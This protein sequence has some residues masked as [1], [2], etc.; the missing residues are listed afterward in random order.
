MK[1]SFLNFFRDEKHNLI[2]IA[3]DIR[4]I[5]GGHDF[6]DRVLLVILADISILLLLFVCQYIFHRISSKFIFIR[7]KICFFNKKKKAYCFDKSRPA[8]KRADEESLL[9]TR[10]RFSVLDDNKRMQRYRC[11]YTRN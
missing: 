8:I 3:L 1:F 2:F 4:N 7:N 9:Y 6:F 5:P 10:Y 11:Y